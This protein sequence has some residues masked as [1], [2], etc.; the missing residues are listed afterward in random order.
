VFIPG[1]G[2]RIE[3]MILQQVAGETRYMGA[4]VGRALE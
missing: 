4:A 2:W 3:K 1:T